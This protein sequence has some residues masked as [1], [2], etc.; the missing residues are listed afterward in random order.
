ME[1]LTA[2]SSLK[3]AIMPDGQRL[4]SVE[5]PEGP[6]FENWLKEKEKS[7]QDE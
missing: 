6:T 3:G 1:Q 4:R 7:Q 2:A 5:N